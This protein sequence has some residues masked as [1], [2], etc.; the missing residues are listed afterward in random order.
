ML[1]GCRGVGGAV[2]QPDILIS[3]DGRNVGVRGGDGRLHLMRP[4]KDAFLIREWLAADADARTATD[5]SL[6]E[7]VSCDDSGCVTQARGAGFVALAQRAEALVDDCD[8]ATLIVTAKPLPQAAPHPS[9][10]SNGCDGTARSRCGEALTAAWWS[11]R[12]SLQ[13]STVHGRRR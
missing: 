1:A 6:T 11:M 7:G 12:S 3:G 10:V 2:P 9:S 13:G 8:R 4:A 5:A